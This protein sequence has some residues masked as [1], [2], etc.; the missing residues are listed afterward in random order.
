[1]KKIMAVL[2]A[3]CLVGLNGCAKKDEVQKDLLKTIQERGENIVAIEG[4][5]S[6]WTYH[7]ENDE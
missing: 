1:M 4:T 7:D 3:L 5:W 2:L 6:P